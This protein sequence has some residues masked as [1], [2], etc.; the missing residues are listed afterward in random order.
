MRTSQAYQI[1][2]VLILHLPAGCGVL[3]SAAAMAT[4]AAFDIPVKG[5][6]PTVTEGATCFLDRS[7]AFFRFSK[8]LAESS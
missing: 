3:F 8:T 5:D 1:D 7:A 4:A 2:I 6:G